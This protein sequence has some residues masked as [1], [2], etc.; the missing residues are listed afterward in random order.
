MNRKKGI[1]IYCI[2][3]I[4]L[5]VFIF[6]T[7][8]I[9]ATTES[10]LN[11]AQSE[12]DKKI[13]ETS[14]EI[15][16]VKSKMTTALNQI[17]KLNNQISSYED[18]ISDL[19]AQIE[20]LTA[21]I[22]EKQE[23]ISVQEKKYEEQ[24]RLLEKRLVALY[25]SGTMSYLDMLLSSD[26]LADFI[27]KY[28]LIAQLAEYDQDLLK[29][30]DNTRIQIETEKNTLE[31]SKKTIEE[32]KSAIVSKKQSLSSSKTEKNKLVK[33]LTAEEKELESQLDEY[34]KDK[35]E[36]QNQINA[37]IKVNGGSSVNVVPSAAGYISPLAGKTK[38]NITCGYHG[39]SGH[40]G[41]DFAIS[42]GTPIRA[43]KAGTV[44]VST[45]LR[46]SNGKYRSYGEYIIIDHHDGTMTLYAHMSKRAVS[47]NQNVSQG[48]TIGYVGS[49]GNSTGPHL[50]FEVF[51]GGKRTNPT[52]TGL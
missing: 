42:S 11:A 52:S 18:E 12:I 34:E 49:T 44:Q 40:T 19:S 31:E 51:V 6:G 20:T 30:I 3:I 13:Q 28:Y 50:H 24:Q 43:V 25:E 5:I 29:N 36:I 7:C 23:N 2:S 27:S 37:L 16:G 10:E 15:Q 45:A 4:I 33:N 9:F 41:V 47:E 48:Q 46:S 38:A 26:G 39:Y 14:T 1:I 32:S 35:R 17:N 22:S 21:Q 8:S